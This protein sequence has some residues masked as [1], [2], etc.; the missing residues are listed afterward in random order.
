M[1]SSNLPP[2]G[3]LPED[4]AE[5]KSLYDN[6][7]SHNV[8]IHDLVYPEVFGQSEYIG[9]FSDNSASDLIDLGRALDLAPGS[10]VL[11]IGCGRGRVARFLAERFGWNITGIDVASVPLAD[12]NEMKRQLEGGLSKQLYFIEGDVYQLSGTGAFDGIYGTGAFCH[13]DASH[14]FSHCADLLR[15]GGR[16]GFMERTRT[17][18]ISPSDWQKLTE[19]WRCPFVY[20]VEE[21]ASTLR[22]SGFVDIRSDDLSERFRDW[23]SRSVT[24]REHM[25]ETIKARTNS[26]YHNTALAHARYEADV[27]RIGSLGYALFTATKGTR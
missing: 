24:V 8:S 3:I 4:V 25:S 9:Q 6:A 20:T 13:F 21:Y 7:M 23:Q 5:I 17:G 11:D 10:K 1:S 26:D 22:E 12:A 27:S 2:H 16:L 19:E 14:L 15:D 18:E